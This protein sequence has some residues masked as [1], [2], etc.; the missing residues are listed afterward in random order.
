MLCL[1][2]TGYAQVEDSISSSTVLQAHYERAQKYLS[3]HDTDHAVQEY[4]LFLAD[5][6]RELAVGLAHAGQYKES[7]SKFEEALNFAPDSPALKLEFAKASIQGGDFDGAKA[8]IEQAE[9][10]SPQ[11]RELKARAHLLMGRI[12]RKRNLND[13]ARKELEQ[14]VDLDP[15]FENGYELAVTC[16]NMEDKDCAAKIFSEMDISFGDSAELHLYAG[17]A[18][19]N[20]D[21][22]TEAVTQFQ[23]AI[24]LNHRLPGAHYSLAAAYLA[25]G[26]HEKLPLAMDELRTEI[27]LFPANAM[28][29]AALGHLETNQ[30]K[31]T[32]AERDLRRAAELNSKS[33]DIFLYLG[34]L[35]SDLKKAAE[36]EAALRTSIQLTT[37]PSRNRYEVQ[38]AHY[39]L[40]RLL[41]QTGDK[42]E[43]RKELDAA[44][45]M[46]NASLERDHERLS[47]YL[48]G[49]SGT[50]AESKMQSVVV[51]VSGLAADPE[52]M[53][54]VAQFRKQIGPAVADSYNNLGAIAA[55]ANDMRTALQCFE[56]AAQWNSAMDGLDLNWGR[57]A[58]AS[59]EFKEAIAPLRR[60]IQ[61][62]PDDKDMRS[63]LG[64]SQFITRDY[65]ATLATLRPIEADPATAPQVA[66]A[67]A[68]SL[69]ETGQLQ[70]GIER[71]KTLEAHTPNAAAIHRALGE[72]L[73]SNGDATSG[74]QELETAIRLNPQSAESYDALGRLQLNQGDTTAAIANLEHAV[75]LEARNGNFHHDLAGAY[76]KAS[77][78]ADAVRENQQY[79]QLQ[80]TRIQ[81]QP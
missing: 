15:N 45:A 35:Y 22:Q 5:A 29:Y 62:H 48:E 61:S 18:Y 52:A 20:S 49:S 32:K 30:Q 43:G 33:P 23:R 72:A 40:G 74:V 79:L 31:L 65:Q 80:G 58:Y 76:Q 12:L 54:Q 68:D 59:G 56:H 39:L 38:K 66:Y 9:Q 50:G 4:R 19:E 21:F 41:L 75:S 26:D 78:A 25:V 46:A 16:L 8:L 42:D 44:K 13:Q 51:D 6:M 7:R 63:A 37:D 69:I 27:R 24:A 60:Y 55:S 2:V 67:Y 34:Q 10:E 28:A 53:R 71:L 81:K 64:L 77:R 11:S 17:R 14:A 73:A 57:A 3:A 70:N 36:A 1:A 47:D